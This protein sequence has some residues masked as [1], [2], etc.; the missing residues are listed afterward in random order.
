MTFER[1]ATDLLL[2]MVQFFYHLVSFNLAEI[3][4]KRGFSSIETD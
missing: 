4:E 3:E 2:G 1:Y